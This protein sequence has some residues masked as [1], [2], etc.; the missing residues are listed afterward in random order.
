MPDTTK[1]FVLECDASLIAT[2]A[3]LRQQDING[4][5]HPVAYLSQSLLPAEWNYKIYDRELLAIIRALESWRHYLHGGHEPLRILTDHKNLTYYQSLRRLNRRQARWHLFLSQFNYKLHHCLGTQ[6]VQSDAMTRNTPTHTADDNV[7]LIL[8]PD[9]VFAKTS[10]HSLH[11]A[12]SLLESN[13]ES[14]RHGA[15]DGNLELAIGRH[16]ENDAYARTIRQCLDNSL[17]AFPAQTTADDWIFDKSLLFFRGRCYVPSDLS[18]RRHIVAL[19]HDMPVSDHPGRFRTGKLVSRDFYWLGL[20]S[21]VS[22]YVQGCSECQQ[23]KVNTHPTRPP[24]QPIAPHYRSRP[25][26]F[27]TCDFI[28][29]LPESNGYS[30]LMVVVDHDSTKGVIIIPCT[31][32]VDTTQTATMYHRNI[33]RRFGLPDKFLSNRGPQFDSNFLKDLWKLT[34]VEGRMSTAYH[35]Q[36]DGEMERMNREIEAYLRILCSNHPHD[37]SEYITN[38]E[39][40]FNNREHSATKHSPFFLMYGSHPKGLPTSYARSR[41]PSVNEWLQ[42]REKAHEEAQSALEHATAQM[43]KQLN[44]RFSPFQEEQKVWLEMTHHEDGYPFKKLA[45][46]RHRPFKIQKVLL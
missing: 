18:I 25:F 12:S 34:G 31:E 8:L 30:A 41:V 21:F 23:M 16:M 5:W 1:P 3:V 13:S 15:V 45:P 4:D 27:T 36:T 6:M 33:F 37:W 22:S 24:F 32:K 28:T 17:L 43:A 44:Q 35:P 10:I 40:A 38:M 20:Q 2:A 26:A 29:A 39:F 19:Y 42:I 7:D 11:I 46:K 9:D 14:P